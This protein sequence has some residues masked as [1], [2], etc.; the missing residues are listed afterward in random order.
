MFHEVKMSA[1]EGVSLEKIIISIQLKCTD[2][3]TV[4]KLSLKF[5]ADF[6]R[7]KYKKIVY[8]DLGSFDDSRF[9]FSRPYCYLYCDWY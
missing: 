5:L 9:S 3:L 7:L 2:V 8:M 4:T 1:L 6:L